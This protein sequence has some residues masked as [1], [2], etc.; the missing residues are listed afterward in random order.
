M[1][2]QILPALILP[3]LLG[4][5]APLPRPARPVA[6]IISQAFGNEAARDRQGEASD[7][8]RIAGI[9]PGMAVADIGTGGGYYVLKAAPIVGPQGR[10]YAQDLSATAL[11][12]VRQ[13]VQTAGYTNVRYVQGRQTSTRL[14]AASVDV[15]LMVHMYHEIE[16]P[17][18]LLDRLRASLKPGGKIVIVDL[19]QPSEAH[20]M[21]KALLVCEVK[22]VGY[23]LMGV[24]DLARGYVAVFRPGVRPDP[25]SV[26][27]CRP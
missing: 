18:L 7:V 23:E 8:L 17:Y 13:R 6:P 16:Q 21:P 9:R 3:A 27:A 5:A 4:A 20:G 1:V 19:D 22:A 10:V 26:R 12:Q 15:A 2:R 14:P 24:T 25:A 11:D